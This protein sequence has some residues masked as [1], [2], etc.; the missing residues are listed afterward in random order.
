MRASP[1]GEV[2][3]P[4]ENVHPAL[5]GN[6]PRSFERKMSLVADAASR[7]AEFLDN[8][9]EGGIS[10][11]LSPNSS[12]FLRTLKMFLKVDHCP[13]VWPQPL[14]GNFKSK[15]SGLRA[16]FVKRYKPGKARSVSGEIDR[17]AREICDN[18]NLADKGL[19]GGVYCNLCVFFKALNSDGDQGK[20]RR[21]PT[22]MDT[23]DTPAMVEIGEKSVQ[24]IGKA[25]AENMTPGRRRKHALPETAVRAR[26]SRRDK[27]PD[28]T[29]KVVAEVN[30][31]WSKGE[32]SRREI[33]D[34]MRREAKW[35]P[36][37]HQSSGTIERYAKGYRG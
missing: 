2:V 22:S 16:A 20:A 9:D 24:A 27:K 3:S 7:L 13:A 29:K 12:S 32:G 36:M 28:D 15:L 21:R 17:L 18:R 26:D 11:E 33:I 4:R 6:T 10:R 31:R 14:T 23:S 1:E 30:R 25:V 37:M 8:G 19:C 35:G 34:K 5:S